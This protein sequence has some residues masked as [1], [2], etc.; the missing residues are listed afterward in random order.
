[1]D[2]NS[3]GVILT[4]FAPDFHFLKPLAKILYQL[5]FPVQDG[6]LWT[7]TDSAP[8]VVNRLYNGIIGGFEEAILWEK[9]LIA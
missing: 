3:F 2:K 6:E 8:A 1:M 5:L 7:G 4:E 9:V